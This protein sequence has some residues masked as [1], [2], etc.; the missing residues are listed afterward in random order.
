[1]R[2][3]TKNGCVADY[4]STREPV[5]GFVLFLYNKEWNESEPHQDSPLPTNHFGIVPSA[6]TIIGKLNSGIDLPQVCLMES[7]PYV[8]RGT[9]TIGEPVWLTAPSSKVQ[10]VHSVFSGAPRA[11]REGGAP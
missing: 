4:L 7:T 10:E 5:G 11:V 2:D 1:M 3:D 6:P 8:P 9:K